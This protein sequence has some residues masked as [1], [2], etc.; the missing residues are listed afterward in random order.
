MYSEPRETYQMV[1]FAKIDNGFKSLFII[2]KYSAL[3]VLQ[4][5]I[6]YRIVLGVCIVYLLLL[7]NHIYEIMSVQGLVYT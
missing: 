3:G 2:A 1:Y 7:S 4:S 5:L 6:F